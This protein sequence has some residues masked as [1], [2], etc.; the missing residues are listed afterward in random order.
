MTGAAD[1]NTGAGSGVVPLGLINSF[2]AEQRRALTEKQQTV[3][4]VFP[5]NEKLATAQEAWLLL[6]LKHLTSV[7]AAALRW[8][9][10]L[11]R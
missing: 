1:A 3:N 5:R 9:L 10:V 11:G 8:R 7:R 6:A 4:K 2:L